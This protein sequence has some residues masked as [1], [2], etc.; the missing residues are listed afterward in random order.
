MGP[1]KL[2]LSSLV[3]MHLPLL[4]QPA[5][6]LLVTAKPEGC[7]QHNKRW[8]D[9]FIVRLL[10]KMCFR[11]RDKSQLKGIKTFCCCCCFHYF[12]YVYIYMLC[13]EMCMRR[14]TRQWYRPVADSSVIS[15]ASCTRAYGNSSLTRDSNNLR[16]A[17][18]RLPRGSVTAGHMTAQLDAA[19]ELNSNNSE[20]M[21]T[22]V[23][24]DV[25]T[26]LTACKFDICN[27]S[28]QLRRGRVGKFEKS[29]YLCC[30]WA[31]KK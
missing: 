15:F 13:K 20:S 8:R 10:D 14:K 27:A 1:R 3:N 22:D 21:R 24:V 16:V 7:C 9:S 18:A 28:R 2:L 4:L 31:K 11:L 25:H 30:M 26:K 29:Q 23:D 17:T 12:V 6:L 5:K 19:A